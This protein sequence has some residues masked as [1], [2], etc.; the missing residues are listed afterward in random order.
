MKNSVLTEKLG[1]SSSCKRMEIARL[2]VTHL[3]ICR[4]ES[5]IKQLVNFRAR[6]CCCGVCIF[7]HA[8]LIERNALVNFTYLLGANM[9]NRR[10]AFGTCLAGA[11]LEVT[12]IPVHTW[13]P[14]LNLR[15]S[16]F[17]L[18]DR[19]YYFCLIMKTKKLLE[20]QEETHTTSNGQKNNRSSE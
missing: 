16:N 3:C 13:P 4:P 2:D 10:I 7:E 8:S 1:G 19:C 15:M 18:S 11:G 5:C 9:G 6:C 14:S 17:S 12:I 20:T